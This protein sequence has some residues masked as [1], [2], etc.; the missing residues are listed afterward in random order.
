[1]SGF[2]RKLIRWQRRH[3]RHDLP[4]QDTL[5]PYRIWLSE[6]MLQQTRVDAVIPYY[7]RFLGRF[8]DVRALARAP[9]GEVLRVWSGLGY[10]ARARNL[11]AA[12]RLIVQVHGGRFPRSPEALAALPGVGRSTAAAIAVFA[13]GGRAA[14][15]DGNVRRVLA[16]CF[17]IEG[18]PGSPAIA[19]RLWSL[20]ESL[21]PVRSIRGYTQGLMDLGAAVCVRTRPRC[22]ICPLA[23]ECVAARQGRVDRIPAPRPKRAVPVRNAR[24]LLLVHRGRVL[25][26]HRP[27]SGLWGGLWTFPQAGRC[28]ARSIR[29]SLGCEIASMR[30][31]PLL[32]HGFTHFRLRVRP[33]LFEVR[34]A[35][36]NSRSSER[37]WLGISEAARSAVPAPVKKLLLELARRR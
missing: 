23:A 32:E 21:L 3:G 15:L 4:W 19:R 18:F 14:I 6:V 9:E 13:F 5:D 8:P 2:A 29:R 30:R 36:P 35:A 11:H 1:M 7:E 10:Y 33:F 20:A 31:L 26:E 25:M 12:S 22:E 37:H 24:W 17:G 28:D 34:D 27:S 16:R